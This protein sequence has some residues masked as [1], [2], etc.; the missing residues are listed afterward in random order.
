MKMKKLTKLIIGLKIVEVSGVILLS[1]LIYL[2]G[3]LVDNKI[4]TSDQCESAL[5]S[6]G[7]G[8][9]TIVVGGVILFGGTMIVCIIITMW[10][11]ANNAIAKGIIK[12]R[13]KKHK[14]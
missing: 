9:G 11:V 5:C 12:R 10:L 3:V 2:F 6:F 14:K 13:N 4:F 7:V 8:F 1:Y